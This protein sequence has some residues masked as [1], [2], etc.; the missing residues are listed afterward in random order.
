MHRKKSAVS[1][2]QANRY[3]RVHIESEN[4]LSLFLSFIRTDC[5]W[6]A[7]FH[8]LRPLPTSEPPSLQEMSC[9]IASSRL[10]FV[11]FRCETCPNSSGAYASRG[12][13]ELRVRRRE[14]RIHAD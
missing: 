9:K 8:Q 14:G 3:F 1:D 12:R 6:E 7:M 11:P 10:D 13:R 4:L 2:H 5:R